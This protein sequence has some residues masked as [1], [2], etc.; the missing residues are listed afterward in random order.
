MKGQAYE[1]QHEDRGK[2]EVSRGHWTIADFNCS[3][4]SRNQMFLLKLIVYSAHSR[5][6]WS[7]S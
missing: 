6:P 2:G 4:L 5:P 3:F 1:A 7:H